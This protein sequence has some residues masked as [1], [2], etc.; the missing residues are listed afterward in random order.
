[1]LQS[2][3]ELHGLEP[4]SKFEKGM[5]FRKPEYRREVFFRF[6][7]F[8]LKYKS[9]PGGVYFLFPYIFKHLSLTK[10]QQ[11]WFA[12]LNGCT[13]N[14]VT[15]WI[16][17]HRFPD[18]PKNTDE[19]EKW[20]RANWKNLMYD[21]DRRYQKGH[22]V[23]MVD[24][25]LANLGKLS[26]EEFFESKLKGATPEESFYKVWDAVRNGFF[27]YGR[28]ST[29]SYLEYLS[30]LG[31]D[32]VCDSFFMEELEGSKSQRN[33]CL[34]VLGRDD[35]DWH[36]DDSKRHSKELI[37]D[38]KVHAENILEEAQNRFKDSSFLKDVN[39]FTLESTFCC[40]KS[41][42]RVN[43]RYPG[44]YNDM[45][46]DRI[47]QGES[48]WPD[49]DFSI[50]WEARR[51]TLPKEIRLEDNPLDIGLKP[52]KMNWYRETGEVIMMSSEWG[53]FENG[54][55]R[56]YVK[57]LEVKD[58]LIKSPILRKNYKRTSIP[59]TQRSLFGGDICKRN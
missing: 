41:W 27:M 34:K 48:L 5:D 1:M 31:L 21:L 3:C 53:C 2:Y 19:M 42:H 43:R 11:Y 59:M 10:E 9:H 39:R 51:D 26:Q 25:Y 15:T 18:L 7:E 47:K 12:F 17:F 30:I 45:L 44:I 52:F 55:E 24:D 38:I 6:Y 46:Y 58:Y 33:G 13:Q 14:P 20:H 29:F 56:D 32:I 35:L 4:I 49:E 40:Y 23:E 16:I 54:Y 50:F 22:L 36:K 57:G 37:E 8:H 28:L